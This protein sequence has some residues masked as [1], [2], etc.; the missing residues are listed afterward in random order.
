[1]KKITYFLLLACFVSF[2]LQLFAQNTETAQ[3][4]TLFVTS[5]KMIEVPSIAS[6]IAD[7]TFIPAQD[8]PKEVNPKRW[9]ANTSVPGKGLPKGNDP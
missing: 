3:K 1:M 9:G 4:A 8:I 5:E 2:G 6:Q 7:G